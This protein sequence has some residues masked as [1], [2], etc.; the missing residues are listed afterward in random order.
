[1]WTAQDAVDDADGAFSHPNHEGASRQEKPE[2]CDFQVF[3]YGAHDGVPYDPQRLQHRFIIGESQEAQKE[4]LGKELVVVIRLRVS[5]EEVV[6]LRSQL[7]G[8][9]ISVIE[10]HGEVII[11]SR[12]A[13]DRLDG[14]R[15]GS[16]VE[17]GVES[18]PICLQDGIGNDCFFPD[19]GFAADSQGTFF[20]LAYPGMSI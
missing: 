17:V 1:M 14:G 16:N 12:Q 18:V 9:C 8:R 19:L 2:A 13:A 6:S 4:G 7:H 11:L 5:S 10:S 3:V 20:A 15:T